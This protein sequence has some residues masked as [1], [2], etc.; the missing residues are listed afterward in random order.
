MSDEGEE[1]RCDELNQGWMGL[2][3]GQS[4]SLSVTEPKTVI[5]QQSMPLPLTMMRSVF[6]FD[7]NAMRGSDCEGRRLE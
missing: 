2:S 5:H 4:P 6:V 7:D 3:M 1:V